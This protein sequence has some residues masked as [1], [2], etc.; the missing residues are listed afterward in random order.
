MKF[1]E[2]DIPDAWEITIDKKSDDRGF[3][4]RGYCEREFREHGIIFN[5]VQANIGYS[6][7]KN[8]LRGLHYQV[9]PDAEQ[10]LIRCLKGAVFDVIA[11]LRPDSATYG[12]WTGVE[13]TAGNYAMLLVPEGC[14]HGY[15]TLTDDAEI[16]YMVS[17]CY[18]PGSERG[19]PWDD[20]AFNIQWRDSENLIISEKDKNWPEYTI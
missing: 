8:T 18:A 12:Q 10:K 5:M 19:I 9:E 13:L 4:G 20:P 7:H 16:F 2:T 6:K 1:R 15:Q 11:D 14:A 3:F 17:A